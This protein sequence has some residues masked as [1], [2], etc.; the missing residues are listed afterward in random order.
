MPVMGSTLIGFTWVSERTFY[1]CSWIGMKLKVVECHIP[2]ISK[3]GFKHI[4][5]ATLPL[6]SLVH[7]KANGTR[8]KLSFVSL[9]ISNGF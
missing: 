9:K 6:L 7:N 5:K 3:M 2:H 8:V 1:W 4:D